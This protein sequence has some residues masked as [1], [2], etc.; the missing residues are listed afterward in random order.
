MSSMNRILLLGEVES[1]PDVRVTENGDQFAKFTLKVNRPQRADGMAQQPDSIPI[2][3]WQNRAEIAQTLSPQSMAFIEGR[4]VTRQTESPEGHRQYFTEVD[5]S[6]IK[7]IGNIATDAPAPMADI[8]APAEFTQA[9]RTVET[10]QIEEVS[11]SDFDFGNAEK[12]SPEASGGFTE[13]EP[14]E[15]SAGEEVPF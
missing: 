1:A 8:P 3:A 11:E 9:P 13:P 4:I 2:V 14:F 15:A 7:P 10:K 6:D 5:A 12:Q